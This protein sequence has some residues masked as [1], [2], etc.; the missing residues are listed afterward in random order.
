MPLLEIIDLVK[1]FGG[2]VANN[3]VS[4]F[5]AEIIRKAF[6]GL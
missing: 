6:L 2:V 4:F 5:I 1:D 3:G